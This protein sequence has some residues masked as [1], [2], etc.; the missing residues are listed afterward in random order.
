V[1]D[2]AADLGGVRTYSEGEEPN[3]SV[4]IAKEE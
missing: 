2:A 4:V 1:H 3:R